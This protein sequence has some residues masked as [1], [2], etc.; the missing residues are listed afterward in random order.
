MIIF[1]PHFATGVISS[2][3]SLILSIFDFP[4]P[5]PL[6]ADMP[7]IAGFPAGFAFS[8]SSSAGIPSLEFY[9]S[10]YATASGRSLES[11]LA[12]WTFYVGFIFFR[13]AAILHGVYARA[14]AG[15]SSSPKAMA[16]GPMAETLANLGWEIVKNNK[17]QSVALSSSSSLPGSA[18]PRTPPSPIVIHSTPS[19][20][21]PFATG[22]HARVREFVHELILPREREFFEHASDGNRKWQPWNGMEQLKRLAKNEGLTNCFQSSLFFFR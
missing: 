3:R 8:S 11:I 6:D 12:N 19:S 1:P 17:G 9:L 21:S 2:Y 7:H 15:Q 4:L 10:A 14:M 18:S 20:L 13:M 22:I 16:L 5:F